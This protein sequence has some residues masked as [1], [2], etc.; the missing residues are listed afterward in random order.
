[1]SNDQEKAV[2]RVVI[3]AG[4]IA[5]V[6]PGAAPPPTRAIPWWGIAAGAVLTPCL[7]L[8]SGAAIAI[9]VAFR[10]RESQQIAWTALL[11]TLLSI[12]GLI[13]SVAVAYAWFLKAPPVLE[14]GRLPLG[15]VSHDMAGSFPSLPAS[16]PLSAAELSAQARLLVFIVMP[17]PGRPLR[18]A[19]LEASPVGAAALL[20]AD[21]NGYLLATNRHVAEPENLF[22]KGQA[23]RVL[24][25]SSPGSYAFADII[26]RHDK[27]DLAL[28]WVARRGGRAHFRQPLTRVADIV[29]G[30]PVYAIGHPERLYFTLSS[31]LISRL[32]EDGTVQLSAPISPGNSG[33]PVY[34]SAGNLLGL[35]TSTVDKQSTPNAENL[36]FATGTDAL[37]SVKGWSF[38]QDGK[39]AL[40]RFIEQGAK[41]KPSHA[42]N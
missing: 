23:E 39:A 34:D 20:M 41:G 13:T 37:L 14:A 35:V 2:E 40:A 11:C 24:V 9:R 26:A 42:N 15:L 3:T 21:E 8:L 17:D 32:G 16:A 31:G 38:R 30:S 10:R 33:G 36:N 22:G 4:E 7:P 19:N 6:E 5:R 28:L 25:V 27:Q 18:N 12:S 29:V 1:M